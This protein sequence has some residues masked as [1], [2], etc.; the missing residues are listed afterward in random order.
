MRPSGNLKGS[1]FHD[2]IVM[3]LSG[4]LKGSVLHDNIVMQRFNIYVFNPLQGQ[5][6]KI[7][8]PHGTS[9]I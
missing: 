3:R 8:Y 7:L 4:N 2:N 6:F 1:V 9:L 5:R